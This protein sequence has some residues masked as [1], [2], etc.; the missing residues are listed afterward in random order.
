MAD[1][2]FTASAGTAPPLD[3]VL[4][5]LTTTVERDFEER[6][7]FPR[8]RHAHAQAYRGAATLHYL[9]ADEAD[10]VIEDAM[11]REKSVRRGTR[12]AYSAHIKSVQAA[13]K[14][15]VERPAVFASPSAVC[16][17]KS[18]H[19]ERWRGT[20]DQLK[21]HGIRLDGPWPHEPGGKER[22]A[23]ARD[24]QGYKTSITRFSTVWPGLYEAYITIPYEVWGP[25]HNE[26]PK[27]NEAD[28]AKRNLASM[29]DSADDFRAHLV[30]SM[31]MMARISL[32]SAIKPATY[33]GYMLDEDAVGEI[34]ASF[35]AVV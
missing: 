16:A 18:D 22:W 12:N 25:K 5:W 28:L 31:R 30:D 35:D 24:S 4:L 9:S 19:A 3:T 11:A 13:M 26:K 20:K 29:P 15:A 2:I 1:A 21:A 10:A 17:Y 8:M 33:H 27:A 14:E 7:A 32:D 6:G 34:H 23:Q